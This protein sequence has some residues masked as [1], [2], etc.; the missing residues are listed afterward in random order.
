VRPIVGSAPRPTRA[1]VEVGQQDTVSPS[2][3]PSLL[4]VLVFGYL[5]HEQGRRKCEA[6]SELRTTVR[7]GLEKANKPLVAA[8]SFGALDLHV[9]CWIRKNF[10]QQN[11]RSG[12]GVPLNPIST[13]RTKAGL[14]AKG[15]NFSFSTPS[16]C[17]S[18]SIGTLSAI[19][20]SFSNLPLPV[21]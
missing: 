6:R 20:R 14:S 13:G 1:L 19:R 8:F 7:T 16:S 5:P 17:L 21:D 10:L 11:T 2:P 9:M 4:I 18:T 3:L 12:T 15:E